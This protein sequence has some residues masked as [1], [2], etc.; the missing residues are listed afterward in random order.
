MLDFDC[1]F[2]II[3]N[4]VEFNVHKLLLS[5]H[6]P[7]FRA[8]FQN[9]WLESRSGLINLQG[10][11]PDVIRNVLNWMYNK[12]FLPT[13]SYNIVSEI[14]DFSDQYLIEDLKTIC[15]EILVPNMLLRSNKQ[16]LMRHGFRFG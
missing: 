10:V 16:A 11:N 9:S 3:V 8:M 2:K 12:S 14:Y 1:D 7:V 4:D 13:A 15:V 5:I 6:S